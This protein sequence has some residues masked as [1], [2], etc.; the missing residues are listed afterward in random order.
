[1]RK[2]AKSMG[3][4]AAT[5]GSLLSVAE[6]HYESMR[7][8]NYSEDTVDARK[9]ALDLFF[10]WCFEREVKRL[11]EL[12][13]PLIERYQRYL[14][15]YRNENGKPLAFS[16]QA[17]R[18]VHVR[19]FCRWSTRKKYLPYNPASEID[20]PRVEAK[21][22]KGLLSPDEIEKV[23]AMPKV[24]TPLGIR[25]RAILE[26]FYSTGMRRSELAK[27]K[28]YDLDI[29]QKTI[30]IFG[31]GKR[32]R[33]NPVGSRALYW[34]EK[35]LHLVRPWLLRGEDTSELFL[36]TGGRAF[37]P[38][39]LTEL[40]GDYIRE[41]GVAHEGACHVF[42]HAMA[43][44][45]LDRGANLKSI[46]QLLG[47]E[48]LATTGKYTL[49]AIEQLKEIHRLRHPG[50]NVHAERAH[51]PSREELLLNAEPEVAEL[52]GNDDEVFIHRRGDEP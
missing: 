22:P 20:L 8:R 38:D 23:I 51:G 35:Y 26:T 12:S 32:E 11:E 42:R 16:T 5:G 37:T 40:V 36:R 18:L 47:H 50:A 27:V 28:L 4:G 34:I 14:Y 49:V 33:L 46:Q 19:E 44:H 45:M 15:Q 17:G 10:R 3:A 24:S 1:M 30:K 7:E 31:K 39:S 43:T 41:S 48:K 25:D 21:L 9:S 52:G 29:P 6:L 2:S 13:T